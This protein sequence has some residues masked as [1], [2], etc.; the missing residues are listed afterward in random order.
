MS[1][2]Q[3]QLERVRWQSQREARESNSPRKTKISAKGGRNW[4]THVCKLLNEET[5]ADR[6]QW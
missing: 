5:H 2:D 3:T 6:Y 4:R 1:K